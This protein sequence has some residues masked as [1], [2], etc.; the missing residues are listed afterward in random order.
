[1]LTGIKQS[2]YEQNSYHNVTRIIE[3]TRN[4]HYFTKTGEL[5]EHFSDL[6][7]L[8]GFLKENEKEWAHP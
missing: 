6:N 3:V 4:F 1:M 5:M 7:I 2:T 8:A